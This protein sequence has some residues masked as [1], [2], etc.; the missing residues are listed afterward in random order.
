LLPQ[1]SVPAQP[2]P[3]TPQYLPP[4]VSHEVMGTHAPVPAVPV[5]PMTAPALP[6]PFAF[7]ARLTLLPPVPGPVPPVLVVARVPSGAAQLP[8]LKNSGATSTRS[9]KNE[10][11]LGVA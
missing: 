10:R 3:I 6:V 8:M 11:F 5:G 4:S 9:A 7:P 1:S 2:L